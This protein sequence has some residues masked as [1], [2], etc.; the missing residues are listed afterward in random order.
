MPQ[1]TA[2]RYNS[3][4]TREDEAYSRFVMKRFM[5]FRVGD[6]L[7]VTQRVGLRKPRYI[8]YTANIATHNGKVIYAKSKGNVVAISRGAVVDGEFHI[9]KI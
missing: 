9:K 7:I 1:C 2:V 8:S 5:Q 4:K 3:A 6:N